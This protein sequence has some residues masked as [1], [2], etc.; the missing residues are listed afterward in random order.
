MDEDEQE[1]GVEIKNKVI[2]EEGDSLSNNENMFFIEEGEVEVY[3]NGT[4][5]TI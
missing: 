4:K 3:Q 5:V 1:M 2:L